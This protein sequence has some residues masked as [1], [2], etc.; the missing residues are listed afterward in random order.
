MALR[1]LLLPFVAGIIFIVIVLTVLAGIGLL[2]VPGLWALPVLAAIGLVSWGSWAA[3]GWYYD[4]A[5]V[6][7]LRE[8]Q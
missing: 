8:R 5:Q 3:Y 1:L 4:R 6:D 7:L 2:V